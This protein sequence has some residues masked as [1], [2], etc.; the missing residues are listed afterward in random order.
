MDSPT[1]SGARKAW[2]FIAMLGCVLGGTGLLL[3]GLGFQDRNDTAFKS[4]RAIC[5]LIKWSEET[6]DESPQVQ[7]QQNPRGR[8]RFERLIGEMRATG[9][10]CPPR[11]RGVPAL[12]GA[13]S[14]LVWFLVLRPE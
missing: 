13:L 9:V 10:A 1:Q 12:G 4:E 3:N 11:R 8:V 6:L 5:A 7:S 14:P 2:R